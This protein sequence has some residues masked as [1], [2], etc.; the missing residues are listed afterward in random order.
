[1]PTGF[2]LPSWANLRLTNGG[3]NP[4]THPAAVPAALGPVHPAVLTTNL[5]PN[6]HGGGLGFPHGVPVAFDLG[7][8]TDTNFATETQGKL[9]YK[10]FID[11][12]DG[13]PNT[14]VPGHDLT[15]LGMG[16]YDVTAGHTYNH[17]GTYTVQVDGVRIDSL[18]S[19]GFKFTYTVLVS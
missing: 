4:V 18:D 13:S 9:G 1:L 17:P 5:T 10:A 8:F 3:T 6:Y 19:T 15:A 16:R 11:W 7:Y 2:N 14:T 12:G